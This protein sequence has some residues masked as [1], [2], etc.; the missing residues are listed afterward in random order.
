MAVADWQSTMPFS[1]DKVFRINSKGGAKTSAILA[2]LAAGLLIYM[3][4]HSAAND[5]QKAEVSTAIKLLLG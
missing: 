4:T 3:L 5:L 2:T 1:C